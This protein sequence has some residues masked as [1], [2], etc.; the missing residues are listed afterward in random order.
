MPDT[1]Y[2]S[3]SFPPGFNWPLKIEQEFG[4]YPAVRAYLDAKFSEENDDAKSVYKRLCDFHNMPKASLNPEIVKELMRGLSL[5]EVW[6]PFFKRQWQPAAGKQV[7]NNTLSCTA[8]V[9]NFKLIQWWMKNGLVSPALANSSYENLS[10]IS[11]RKLALLNEELR[12]TEEKLALAQQKLQAAEMK[13]SKMNPLEKK[14]I[15]GFASSKGTPSQLGL[16]GHQNI[17]APETGGLSM[18]AND[19]EDGF[20]IVKHVAQT[21]NN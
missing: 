12:R 17:K 5:E 21:L 1:R 20:V 13:L 2:Y 11:E 7:E 19:E 4:Q 15:S 9:G 10:A 8:I 16:M 14:D 6:P 3:D 18:M